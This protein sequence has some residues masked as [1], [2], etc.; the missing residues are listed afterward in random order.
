M[1]ML[2]LTYLR[3]INRLNF[4]S[5]EIIRDL[6][7]DWS[8]EIDRTPFA[9]VVAAAKDLTWTRDPFDRLIAAQAICTGAEL[10]TA[11]E[12]M[13]KHLPSARW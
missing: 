12:R 8:I 11:D 9:D 1:A 5:A 2:E 3:D 10:L 7:A 6:K 13:L 4:G